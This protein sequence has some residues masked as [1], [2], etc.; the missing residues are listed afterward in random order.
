MESSYRALFART[1][2]RSLALSCGLGWLSFA[3][4]GLA[5][6]L[7]VHA[8]THSFADVGAAV[9]AFSAGS[10]IFAPLRGRYVDRRGPRTLATFGLFHGAAFAVLVAACAWS[11]STWLLL[12]S[13][14]MGGACVPPLIAT[15]RSVWPQVSGPE[16]ARTGHALNAAMGDAVQVVGPPVVGAVAALASPVVALAVLVPSAVVGALLVARTP[17][18]EVVAARVPAARR[19]VGALGESS[20]LRTIVACAFGLGVCLGAL[21]VAAPAIAADAGA[22]E[23]AAIPLAA[24]ALGSIG[25]SLWTGAGRTRRSPAW[26]Y[27]VGMTALAALLMLCL[28]VGTLGGITVALVGAGAGFGLMNVA[29]F[30][31]LDDVAMPGRA[32]EALTWLTSLQGAGLAVGA[33]GA[34]Q[35][36][37]SGAPTTLL[38]VALPA[39][40]AAALAVARRATLSGHGRTLID[41]VAPLTAATADDSPSAVMNELASP[42]GPDGSREQRW[43]ARGVCAVELGVV[44]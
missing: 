28:V 2:A 6:V 33:V 43:H 30:E 13:A 44:V 5:I 8:A 4:Y 20:G 25:V 35:L 11:H 38:L 26:R 3:S 39:G 1:G 29:A 24:F 17:R 19:L 7:A 31:L 40:V 18:P 15:A 23:L 21:D 34:G 16:L 12:G 36:S 27:V 42:T 37:H 14:A 41:P 32:V 10:G 9:G 22:T